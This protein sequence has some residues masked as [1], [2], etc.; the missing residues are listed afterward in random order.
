MEKIKDLGEIID[1][2][3]PVRLSAYGENFDDLILDK[4]IY[5]IKLSETFYPALSILEVTFRNRICK[6]VEKLICSD[7]LL[8]ELECRAILEE[9][10]HEKLLEA[11][12]N[13]QKLRKK[14]TNDRL[15][16]EMTF[17]FWIHLCTKPYKVKLWDKKGFFEM[18]FPNYK[19]QGK[20]RKIGFIHNNLSDILRLRNRI[21][22]HEII[23]NSNKTP[24]EY[25]QLIIEILYLLSCPM[26]ILLNTI[27]RFKE[28]IKQKPR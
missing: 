14:V 6:A 27:S 1:V 25:Y 15:I 10:E 24:E 8:K 19:S 26:E 4:Y 23:I 3:T 22:H 20:L 17:G 11:E 7:W 2:I 13:L 9:K 12:K 5:N 16:A 21:F 28:V 18:V